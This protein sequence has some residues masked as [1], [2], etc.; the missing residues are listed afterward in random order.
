MQVRLIYRSGV[1]VL[2]WLVLL[3][4]SSA[5]ENAEILLLRQ[6]VA[7]LRQVNPGPRLEWTDRAVIAALSLVLPKGLRLHRIAAPGTL[8]RGRRIPP[9]GRDDR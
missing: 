1:A 8:L 2:S 9:T 5:S 6:E 4:S 3:A 7:V